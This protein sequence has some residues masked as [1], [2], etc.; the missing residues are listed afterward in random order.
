MFPVADF[1]NYLIAL[2]IKPAVFLV[3]LLTEFSI[4][5]IYLTL[6]SSLRRFSLILSRLFSLAASRLNSLS[7]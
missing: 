6:A 4:G 1:V 7:A 3:N 5:F 2:L